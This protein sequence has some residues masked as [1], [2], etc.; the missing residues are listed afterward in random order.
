MQVPRVENFP[1]R[2]QLHGGIIQDLQRLHGCKDHRNEQNAPG[3]CYKPAGCGLDDHIR[4]NL[5]RFKAWAVAV[6]RVM[7]AISF[8][9]ADTPV[10][11]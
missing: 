2:S 3:Y 1:D 11:V 7:I 5:R 8:D 9:D 10:T 4:L 6:V